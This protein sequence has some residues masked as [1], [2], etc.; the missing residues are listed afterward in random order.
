M[1]PIVVLTV[2]AVSNNQPLPRI[3]CELRS[4]A[5]QYY[6]QQQQW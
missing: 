2:N 5:I 6:P 1:M 4:T 3:L